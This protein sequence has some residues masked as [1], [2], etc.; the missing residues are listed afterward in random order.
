M[1]FKFDF[2]KSIINY[3]LYNNKMI[4]FFLKY[5]NKFFYYSLSFKKIFYKNFLIKIW[6]IW[7]GW[8]IIILR[9]CVWWKFKVGS[10]D[11]LKLNQ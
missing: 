3:T 11:N 2:Y 9:Y 7:I 4:F 6:I 5:L 10:S 1:T 8:R